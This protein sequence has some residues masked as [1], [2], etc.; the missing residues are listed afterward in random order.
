MNRL[1]EAL[2]TARQAE[3]A[4][5]AALVYGESAERALERIIESLPEESADLVRSAGETAEDQV[6][7]ESMDLRAARLEAWATA[8]ETVGQA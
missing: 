8:L 1:K 2:Q 7:C 3:A 5:Q 6:A 4:Y